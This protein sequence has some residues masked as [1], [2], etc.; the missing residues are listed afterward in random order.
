MQRA[1]VNS[2]SL[3]NGKQAKYTEMETHNQV[4]NKQSGCT[5]Y[6]A[7][8]T[9]YAVDNLGTYEGAK[10]TNCVDTTGQTIYCKCAI[11]SLME[12]NRSISSDSLGSVRSDILSKNRDV[13]KSH[14]Q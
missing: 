12:K 9:A 6:Q 11:P 1:L 7:N 2:P 3:S 5:T 13:V 4:D 10:N 8:T 14:L